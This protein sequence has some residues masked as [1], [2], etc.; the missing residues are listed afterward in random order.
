MT[1]ILVAVLMFSVLQDTP[2]SVQNELGMKNVSPSFIQIFMPDRSQPKVPIPFKVTSSDGKSATGE[3]DSSGWAAIPIELENAAYYWL[4]IESDQQSYAP[5][6][7]RITQKGDL[8]RIYL[9]P[10]EQQSSKMSGPPT[11]SVAGLKKPAGNARAARDKGLRAIA[12]GNR[13]E[14]V[15]QFERAVT[16]DPDYLDAL[17]D[18]GMALIL[19]GKIEKAETVLI[20]AM[21]L[22]PESGIARINLAI[23]WTKEQR[24]ESA[25]ES[26]Q[27][28]LADNPSSARAL[29]PLSDALAGQGRMDEAETCLLQALQSKDLT[30][31]LEGRIQYK[32]GQLQVARKR[33]T[34]A[35]QALSKAARLL[36]KDP[37][38]HLELGNVAF[39]ATQFALAE[40]EWKIASRLGGAAAAAA[41]LE[42]GRIYY[43]QGKKSAAKEAFQRFLSENHAAPEA[44]EIRALLEK[45]K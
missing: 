8:V 11:V 16:L 25:I 28:V 2:Q 10:I 30:P 23:V 33:Y 18:L 12:A 24:Y 13:Q 1:G 14:A 37:D 31:G 40:R 32:Y 20:H 36:P 45:L 3:T 41:Q 6:S 4:I 19:T 27:R 5:L 15:A 21:E 43:I 39:S 42:L 34:A 7:V 17:N 26:L 22:S 35:F 44:A 9:N 29:V 38:V